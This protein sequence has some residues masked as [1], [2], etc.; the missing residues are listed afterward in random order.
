MDKLKP[1]PFCNHRVRRVVGY[2]GLHYFRCDGCGAVVS[3]DN[4]YCNHFKPE[5]VKY[6]NRR[7]PDAEPHT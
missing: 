4:S 2:M 6:W 3:F 7:C 5:A 1:C